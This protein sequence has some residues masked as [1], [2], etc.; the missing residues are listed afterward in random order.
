MEMILKKSE[1]LLFF[2]AVVSV[3]NV[4]LIST[5]E[6]KAARPWGSTVSHKHEFI[7]LQTRLVHIAQS[8]DILSPQRQ[9][10]GLSW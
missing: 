6:F 4:E 1:F 2:C 7:Y 8:T 3:V 10:Y 9:L 5:P